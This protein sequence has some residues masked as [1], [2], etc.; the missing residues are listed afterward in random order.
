MSQ[1]RVPTI[2]ISLIC[3]PNAKDIKG[4][5]SSEGRRLAPWPSPGSVSPL[6]STE[7]IIVGLR[8]EV[9]TLK[10]ENRELHHKILLQS[11]YQQNANDQHRLSQENALR[12]LVSTLK[13]ANESTAA[14]RAQVATQAADMAIS[15]SLA[16]APD[17]PVLAAL[18]KAV[19]DIKEANTFF[20]RMDTGEAI[21]T[22][23]P[24]V[25]E[26]TNEC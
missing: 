2:V 19:H 1:R 18:E 24:P 17:L 14:L 9:K 11:C 3:I 7:S 13:E 8:E 16:K 6:V 5:R 12:L 25:D 4:R 10:S 23:N 15:G 26:S 22:M 21:A 20:A